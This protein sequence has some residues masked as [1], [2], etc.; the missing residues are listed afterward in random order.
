MPGKS[1]HRLERE[2]VPASEDQLERLHAAC[3]RHGFPPP[4]KDITFAEASDALSALQRRGS[5]LM[6]GGSPR[7]PQ[8]PDNL[9]GGC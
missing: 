7:H 6:D 2:L 4:R 9:E 1:Y 8:H 3:K 5:V